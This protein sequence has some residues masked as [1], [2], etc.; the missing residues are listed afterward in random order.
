VIHVITAM[1][2]YKQTFNALKIIAMNKTK[3]MQGKRLI[4]FPV[5]NTNTNDYE[6]K[7]KGIKGDPIPSMPILP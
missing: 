7:Q 6:E 2:K 3:V 4:Q 5:I 1:H